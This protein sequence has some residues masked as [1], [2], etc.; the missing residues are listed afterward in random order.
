[1]IYD[2]SASTYRKYINNKQIDNF[3]KNQYDNLSKDNKKELVDKIDNLNEQYNLDR[4][5][6]EEV[7]DELNKKLAELVEKRDQLIEENKEVEDLYNLAIK[8]DEEIENLKFKISELSKDDSSFSNKIE[9]LTSE[10]KLYKDKLCR[11]EESIKIDST[12]LENDYTK[13]NKLNAYFYCGGYNYAN[14]LFVIT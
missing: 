3:D 9:S 12:E 2:I 6:Y 13:Y 1:M 8:Q 5:Q 14:F 4:V 11:L 10:L 7:I